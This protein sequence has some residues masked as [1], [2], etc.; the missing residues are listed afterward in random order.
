MLNTITGTTTYDT[1]K[2]GA[3]RRTEHLVMRKLKRTAQHCP[4]NC[5][6]QHEKCAWNLYQ[7]YVSVNW[8][9][10]VNFNFGKLLNFMIK[11]IIMIYKTPKWRIIFYHKYLLNRD[12]SFIY[13]FVCHRTGDQYQ[14]LNVKC[15]SSSKHFLAVVMGWYTRPLKW[16]MYI[17]HTVI[18]CVS[19]LRLNMLPIGKIYAQAATSC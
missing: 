19:Q 5:M 10:S 7:F 9:T 4:W 1:N 3:K 2:T 15:T 13:L 18:M 11:D 6:L 8:P 12:N 14:W 17:L 16:G